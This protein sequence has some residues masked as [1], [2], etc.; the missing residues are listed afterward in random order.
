MVDAPIPRPHIIGHNARNAAMNAAKDELRNKLGTKDYDKGFEREVTPEDEIRNLIHSNPRLPKPTMAEQETSTADRVRNIKKATS[1]SIVSSD[2]AVEDSPNASHI[3][4][5]LGKSVAMMAVKTLGKRKSI[6]DS[7]SR[8]LGKRMRRRYVYEEVNTDPYTVAKGDTLSSIAKR[9]NTT[10]DALAADNNIK[11]VNKISIGQKIVSKPVAPI[12]APRLSSRMPAPAERAM[13]QNPANAKP[14]VGGLRLPTTPNRDLGSSAGPVSGTYRDANTIS[15]QNKADQDAAY[16]DRIAQADAEAAVKGAEMNAYV[17]NPP[18]AD[19]SPSLGMGLSKYAE[20]FR[21][22]LV[23]ENESEI[24]D[25]SSD[26]ENS[27]KEK[28]RKPEKRG[29]LVTINAKIND[30][31]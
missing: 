15:P 12:P 23:K 18:R 22:N 27:P 1:L 7:R 3:N 2:H 31:K 4:E 13:S 29:N 16:A 5:N 8:P 6:T 20:K 14:S 25:G 17:K 9:L 28:N 26:E 19:A 30:N 24:A 11:D 10:V 21:Q